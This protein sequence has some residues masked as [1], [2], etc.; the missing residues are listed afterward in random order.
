MNISDANCRLAS[1]RLGVRGPSKVIYIKCFVLFS[2][3]LSLSFQNASAQDFSVNAGI[4][5]EYYNTP[6]LSRY[7]SARTGGVTPGVYT[8][9]VQ[10]EAGAEYFILN[11]WLVGIE[12]GYLPSQSTGNGY[13]ISYSYSLPCLTIRK[14]LAGDNYYLRIGGGIGYHFFSLNQTDPYGGNIAYSSSGIGL[15]FDA[16][17]DSKLGENFYAR[18]EG[19]AHAE[20]TGSFKSVD[21]GTHYSSNLSGVGVTFGLVYYF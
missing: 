10:L 11:D 6:S 2:F 15:K 9:S 4:G 13:Q 16:A 7:L 18:V 20:F 1:G 14:V 8:T 21:N 3:A 17:L 5:L 12:Y 19:D